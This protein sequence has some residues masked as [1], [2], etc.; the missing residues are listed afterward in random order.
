[1]S[2]NVSELG[3]ADRGDVTDIELEDGSEFSGVIRDVFPEDGMMALDVPFLDKKYITLRSVFGGHR[4]EDD[5]D[6]IG[7]VADVDV[8][9]T[10]WNPEDVYEVLQEV[11]EGDEVLVRGVVTGL[12]GDVDAASND[13]EVRREFRGEV[14]T[15]THISSDDG[16]MGTLSIYVDADGF[17]N[18]SVTQRYYEDVVEEA[19]L[20][21]TPDGGDYQMQGAADWLERV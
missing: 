15:K 1:M 4:V 17:E 16:D 11:E 18:V 5:G 20:T 21:A 10:A 19:S 8:R 13:S 2:V 12:L 7:R 14:D 3:S 9:S 6:V